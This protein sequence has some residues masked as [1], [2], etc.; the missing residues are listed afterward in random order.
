MI[1]II[2]TYC[3]LALVMV[4]CETYKTFYGPVASDTQKGKESRLDLSN[5]NLVTVQDVSAFQE[6]RALN[7]SGNTRLDIVETLQTISQPEALKILRLDSLNLNQLP[8]GIERFKNL[9]QLSLAGNPDL[10]LAVLFDQLENF[11]QLEFLNLKGNSIQQLPENITK[12]KSIKDLN[13]AYNQLHD[14]KSYIYLGALPKL[15]NLWLDHNNLDVLPDTI[16]DVDQV[17]YLYLNHNSLSSL[18]RTMENMRA[19]VI[20]IGYNKFKELPERFIAMKSLIM[21]HINNNEISHIPEAWDE[22]KFSLLAL[23]LDNNQLPEEDIARAKK[24]FRNFFLLSFQQK[25]FGYH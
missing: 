16:G 5:Q 19:R 6:L 21:V 2:V 9:K 15:F 10:D 4:G 14:A 17:I 24:R 8:N 3:V 12:L 1:R 23:L 7:L 22:Q 11:E 25:N 18:P 13:L 20:H